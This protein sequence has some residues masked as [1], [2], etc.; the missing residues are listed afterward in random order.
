MT[1]GTRGVPLCCLLPTTPRRWTTSSSSSVAS[2]CGDRTTYPPGRAARV[3]RVARARGTDGAGLP[4]MRLPHER[5]LDVSQLVALEKARGCDEGWASSAAR[6][7]TPAYRRPSVGAA[8]SR[9]ASSPLSADI[10]PAIP[11]F[12]LRIHSV[13]TPCR[14]P[15]RLRRDGRCI[16]H[17]AGRREADVQRLRAGVAKQGNSSA[18]ASSSPMQLQSHLCRVLTAGEHFHTRLPNKQGHCGRKRRSSRLRLRRQSP[19]RTKR[20]CYAPLVWRYAHFRTPRIQ[21]PN[22]AAGQWAS[23]PRSSVRA[24]R[25][26]VKL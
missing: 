6:T 22:R 9:Q 1:C 8:G 10:A 14:G 12:G 13:L 21:C 19:N 3:A 2:A 25:T 11:Q 26:P 16:A 17:G 15:N 20:G 23:R 4:Q 18:G 5:M 7:D 24:A